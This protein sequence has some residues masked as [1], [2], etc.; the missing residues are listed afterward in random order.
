MCHNEFGPA[1]E[2]TRLL[3]IPPGHLI[4]AF[5]GSCDLNTA[6]ILVLVTLYPLDRNKP[7]AIDSPRPGLSWLNCLSNED[8]S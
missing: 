3:V 6:R 2:Y 8:N 1:T 4:T 7:D 5:K